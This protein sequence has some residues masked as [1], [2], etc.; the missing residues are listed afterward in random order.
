MRENA[1]TCGAAISRHI[2]NSGL[3][4]FTSGS[5]SSS[6]LGAAGASALGSLVTAAVKSMS[7][8]SRAQREADALFSARERINNRV[9]FMQRFHQRVHAGKDA[10]G[11]P[12]QT[13]PARSIRAC[14]QPGRRLLPMVGCGGPGGVCCAVPPGAW[15]R[16]L[17]HGWHF[18]TTAKAR[19]TKELRAA[20]FAPVRAAQAG[21]RSDGSG[22]RHAV[23]SALQGHACGI[24]AWGRIHPSLAHAARPSEKKGLAVQSKP[25]QTKYKLPLQGRSCSLAIV[26]SRCVQKRVSLGWG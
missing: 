23:I 15:T 24:V 11:I 5:G 26:G 1:R 9:R 17:L 6:R 4:R 18:G 7:S 8:A 21:L 19:R 22:Y 3:L 14:P 12:K 16:A 2:P 20:S 25:L 10:Q 13:W